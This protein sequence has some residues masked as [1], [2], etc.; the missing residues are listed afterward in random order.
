MSEARVRVS[1]VDGTIEIEGAEA[2]VNAALDKFGDA[3][4]ARIAPADQY[5]APPAPADPPVIPS[6]TDDLVDLTGIFTVTDGGALRIAANIPGR[7]RRQQMINAG[8]LL[9]YAAEQIQHRRTVPLT[10]VQATCKAHRCY[11]AKNLAIALRKQRS[12]FIFG[13]RRRFQTLALTESGREDAKKLVEM[14]AAPANQ[15]TTA[16]PLPQSRVM[17][18]NAVEISS[19]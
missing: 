15:P 16:A 3:I 12:A 18:S 4:R 7:N 9:A 13:G 11:D 17:S 14:I 19:L 1:L 8:K 2:F 5:P 10:D 6:A